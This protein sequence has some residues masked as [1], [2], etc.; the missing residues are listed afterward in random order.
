M[1][2]NA[3]LT[4]ESFEF[5]KLRAKTPELKKSGVFTYLVIPFDYDEGD[6]IIKING[7][8]RVFKHVNAG[9]VNYSL[10]I[11]IDDKH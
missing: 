3:S 4:T 10:A 11:S 9:R 2:N 1:P 6:P 7:N 8:F 5:E